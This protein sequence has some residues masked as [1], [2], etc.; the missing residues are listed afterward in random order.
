MTKSIHDILKVY[1]QLHGMELNDE[2][3]AHQFPVQL[4]ED[5]PSALNTGELLIAL[6]TLGFDA[7]LCKGKRESLKGIQL[8]CIM[9]TTDHK[10][11]LVGRIDPSNDDEEAGMV[12]LQ[13]AGD[14]RPRKCRWPSLML[15]LPSNGLK[16][17]CRCVQHR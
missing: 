4:E 11:M 15:C 16:L 12:V 3:F 17:C 10:F 6:E 5:G 8:P 7:S 9:P 2:Q 14:P 13:K 1:C